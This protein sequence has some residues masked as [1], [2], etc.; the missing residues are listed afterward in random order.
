MAFSW[1]T[2][3]PATRRLASVGIG[4][5]VLGWMGLG[6]TAGA[7][8]APHTT[9]PA[10]T[11]STPGT[12]PA[13]APDPQTPWTV[14]HPAPWSAALTTLS[15]QTT[16]LARGPHGTIV[17]AMASWCLFCGYEDRWVWPS[18]A[19]EHPQW[20][21]DIVDVSP[22]GGIADPG[23]QNPPFHGHDG[24]GGPLSV[25]QMQTTMQHYVQT[26]GLHAPNIHVYVA[27]TATQSAWAVQSFPDIFVINAAGQIVQQSPGAI[28]ASGVPGLLAAAQK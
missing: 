8:L 5:A 25:A 13:A 9:T 7:W 17:M 6:F 10:A 4:V 2:L 20:A 23:P 22:Q 11:P 16:H 18:V 24:V 28:T 15:G 3:A 27:P 12:T 21:I 26:Y 14:G 1:T 19:R